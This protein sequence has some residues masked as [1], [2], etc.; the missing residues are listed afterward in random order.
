[1][2]WGVAAPSAGVKRAAGIE[3]GNRTVVFAGHG[4]YNSVTDADPF[5]VVPAGISITFWCLHGNP[6]EGSDLDQRMNIGSFRPQHFNSATPAQDK[7][8]A[9]GIGRS[10]QIGA[11][12]KLP[13]VLKAGDRCYNYRLTPPSG[14]TLKNRAN[15]DRFITVADRSPSGIGYLLRDLI[16]LHKDKVINSTIH[17]AACRVVRLR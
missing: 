2:G 12:R 5:F 14:L 16:D 1:M 4:A 10:F 6:F 15:D 11:H 9:S 17:W 13:E 7:R 3:I 8:A